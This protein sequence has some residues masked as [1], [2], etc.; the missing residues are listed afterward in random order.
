METIRDPRFTKI[1][2]SKPEFSWIVPKG[3]VVQKAYQVLV[4]SS[5]EN[6]YNNIGDVWNSGVVNNNQSVN[7]ELASEPLKPNTTYF[8]KVRIFDQ[9]NRLSEYSETQQFTTGTFGEKQTSQDWFE[10]EKIKPARFQKEADGTYFADFG[11]DAFG[12]LNIH[13][14]PSQKETLTIRLGEKLLDGK[15]DRDPGGT[16]RY[17]ELKMDISPEKSDYQIE[18]IPDKRNTGPA[19]VALPDSFPVVTP[20]RYVE[21]TRDSDFSR[22]EIKAENLTQVAYFTYFNENASSF[23]SSDTI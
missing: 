7:V 14:S 15:I 16:I 23:T 20:F 21:I 10:I 5:D 2:D 13:Y 6:S 9:D 3:A 4:S 8:W 1:I 18:L 12:T 22:S 11:K 19:A 17:T